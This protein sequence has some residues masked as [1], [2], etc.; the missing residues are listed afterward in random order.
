[1][2]RRA[3]VAAVLSLLG[4]CAWVYGAGL[5]RAPAYLV[6]DEVAYA[7]NAH[8]IATTLH[9][10]NGQFLPLSFHV[11]GG[12]FA[13]PVNIYVTALF[14]KIL[15][16]TEVTTRLP[17]V[18][19]GLLN[20]ALLFGIA[21]RLFAN[22]W[23]P[24]LAAA[25]FALTPAHFIHSR[26]G[27]DHEYAVTAVLAWALCL[28]G[29]EVLSMRRLAVAG[30]ILGAGVYTY[31]GALITM[32]VCVAITWAVLWRKGERS[33]VPFAAVAAGFA[34]ILLPFAAWH[35]SHPL[36]YLDQM[37]MYSLGETPASEPVGLSDRVAVY[38]DYFN[39]SFLFFAGD[40][41]LINGTRYTG[42]FLL[43]VLLLWLVGLAR[44]LTTLK[45]PSVL[46]VALGL[47]MAP[48]AAAV[49]GEPYRINRA[50]VL[51]PFVSLIVAMGVEVMWAA[52]NTWSRAAVILLLLLMPLQF[53]GF[54]R[55]YFGDYRLRSAKWLEYNI[56]GGLEEIIRQQPSSGAAPIYIADNIQWAP[57]YWQ[58]YQAKHGRSDLASGTTFVDVHAFD[59]AVIPAGS[60]VLCRIHDER[61]LL[62]A[63]LTRVAAVPEPDGVPWFAVLRR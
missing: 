11:T 23:L 34:L 1:M 37:K 21:R 56:G 12:F 5:D 50:L 40:T 9:D 35:L 51:L 44:L 32:P 22:A 6:H 61:A 55:D 4:V 38:W 58:F 60:V 13:T 53:A 49:V 57:Y 17:S 8:A 10:I 36:Q 48:L 47:L 45:S 24:V 26:L 7:I 39:P 19:I 15:P 3:P 25:V 14:L 62:A 2:H 54:Y 46:L 29:H 52:R 18:V 42:V 41:G 31:L 63:G 33:I 28:V 30:A 20:I 27:T 16:L 43:P 59:A